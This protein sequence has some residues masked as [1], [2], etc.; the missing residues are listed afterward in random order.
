MV[1]M[2]HW[3]VPMERASMKLGLDNIKNF[4]DILGNPHKH[5]PPVIHV[6]GTNGKGSTVAFVRAILEASGL[7]VHVYTSPHLVSFNERIVVSGEKIADAYLHSILEECRIAATKND[8]QVSFFEGTTAAAFLA[9]SRIKADI[10]LLETGLGGRLDATN[11]IDNPVLT[12]ITPISFDHMDMLGDS[13]AKIAY[14]KSCIM[15]PG[16]TSIISMQVQEAE[17]VI[18]KYAEKVGAQLCRFEYDFGIEQRNGGFVY[19]AEGCELDLP[20][21]SLNGDHQYINAATAIAAV[22]ILNLPQITDATILAG[23]QKTVWPGRLQHVSD[24]LVMNL[25]ADGFELWLDGAHNIA[26][27]R[28]VANWLESRIGNPV[29][30]IVGITKKR[31]IKAILAPLA[32]LVTEIIAVNVLS[33]PLSY[34]ASVVANEAKELGFSVSAQEDVKDAL[35]YLAEKEQARATILVTGSLFLVADTSNLNQ[36]E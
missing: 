30:V 2:P 14:E 33:E 1:K 19:R 29:Y 34:P 27:M 23:L 8:L 20:K 22:K 26:G 21:L 32:N 36:R 35:L 3:P 4:L 7:K 24:G 18:E 10:V 11:V 12:V 25:V 16:V 9:F 31:D 13:I 28:A 5:L 15:R 17:E 6:A